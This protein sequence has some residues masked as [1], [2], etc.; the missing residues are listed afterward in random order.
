MKKYISVILLATVMIAVL[1]LSGCG[2]KPKAPE[3]KVVKIENLADLPA[4]IDSNLIIEIPEGLQNL[5]EAFGYNYAGQTLFD[6]ASLEYCGDGYSLTIE[7]VS[8]LTIRG[9]GTA[10]T[11]FVIED[12]YADVIRFKDCDGIKLEKMTLGHLV[13]P[14]HCVGAVVEVDHCKNVDL[15]DLDLYGCGTYGVEAI[16]SENV[17]LKNSIIRECSYGIVYA[18]GSKL[19]IA[20]CKLNECD[21]YTAVEAYGSTVDFKN[22][23]FDNNIM[24]SG[25]ASTDASKVNFDGCTF[26]MSESFDIKYGIEA[27]NNIS[28]NNCKFDDSIKLENNIVYV[29]NAKELF[30]AVSP[31]TTIIV[32]NGWCEV[33]DWLEKTYLT[34]GEEWNYNHQY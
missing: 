18:T 4:A 16:D 28:F 32:R 1:S 8:N 5:G 19:T 22:C 10:K 31:N 30:E 14:G 2:Q 12:P 11:E 26:S 9:A 3:T 15:S 6:H 34:Y 24:S 20:D 29:S 7:K 27:H 23:K 25:F 17:T 33:S 21:G 13:E